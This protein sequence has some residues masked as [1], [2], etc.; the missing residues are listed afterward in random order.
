M[1]GIAG[2]PNPIA[3]GA[4]EVHFPLD[5]ISLVIPAYNEQERI[6]RTLTAYVP[7]L[8]HQGEAFEII[9]VVDGNDGTARVVRSAGIPEATIVSSNVKLGK[10]GAILCGFRVA[11][12]STVGYVDADG[13]LAP[14]DLSS[15]IE[16][17]RDF[18]CVIASR[19]LKESRW[20]REEPFLKRLLGRGFNIMVRSLLDIPVSDTQCG[21]KFYRGWLAK[22]LVREVRVTNL[23]TDVSFLYHAMLDGARI[24]EVPVSWTDH[25]GSRFTL[26]R[27]VVFMFVTLIGIRLMNHRLRRFVPQSLRTQIERRL[28]NF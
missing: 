26:P 19:W 28:G 23:T 16:K 15:L 10:G 4:A 21:A 9:V 20:I 6:L 27:L 8:Q 2:T 7:V 3:D 1:A 14:E 24:V 12:F 11:K 18:D 17:I 25:E 22:R 5:G 13:S